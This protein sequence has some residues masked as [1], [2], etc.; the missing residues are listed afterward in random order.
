MQKKN[1]KFTEHEVT[2]PE[3]LTLFSLFSSNTDYSHT[4]N[5]Y[6]EIPR[7]FVGK[8]AL[9]N[10]QFLLILERIFKVGKK[11]YQVKIT[12]ARLKNKKGEERDFYIGKREDVIEDALRKIAADGI[13]GQAVYLDGQLAV[14]FTRK[15][16][17]DELSENGHSYSYDQIEESLE[18]LTKSSIELSEEGSEEKHFFHPIE[19]Y[20]IKGKDGESATYVKFSQFVTKSIKNNSFRLINYKKL[21]RYRSVIAYK[22]HKKLTHHFTYASSD[23]TYHFSLNETFQNFGLLLTT[24]PHHRMVEM[25]K[26]LEEL[27]VSNIVDTFET[28]KVFNALRKNKVDDYIYDIYPHREFISDVITANKD[29]NRRETEAKIMRHLPDIYSKKFLKD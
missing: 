14:L 18:V 4:I 23:K 1:K 27:K 17:F 12:P 29:L 9:I 10:N 16:L 8:P 28:R 13:R 2:N 3:Q 20:G 5:L 21:L 7:T 19:S 24:N 6:D 15:A 26:A 11:K 25:N 22:L